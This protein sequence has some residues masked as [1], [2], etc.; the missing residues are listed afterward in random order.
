[1]GSPRP[2]SFIL[3]PCTLARSTHSFFLSVRVRMKVEGV[4]HATSPCK[5]TGE[6]NVSAAVLWAQ[7]VPQASL[8]V[9]LMRQQHW[10][11]AHSLREGKLPSLTHSC[12]T[13]SKEYLPYR[14]PLSFTSTASS[15]QWQTPWMSFRFL[16]LKILAQ[17]KVLFRGEN[18]TG[19]SWAL[20]KYFAMLHCLPQCFWGITNSL[21]LF[22][23]FHKVLP[24]LCLS[25]PE[26][27]VHFI[28]A[29][30]Y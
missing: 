3:L 28:P 6:Y 15:K 16:M 30:S 17:R 11:I 7:P 24:L 20:E 25:I 22:S 1:M 10:Q 8:R 26:P 19:N 9:V 4:R 27:S 2:L 12:N 5:I 29:K 21:D 14:P 18:S 13:G 23:V